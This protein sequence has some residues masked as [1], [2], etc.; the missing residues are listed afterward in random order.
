A[1]GAHRRL[2]AA[3]FRTRPLVEMQRP[4]ETAV[5]PGT[6]AFTIAR[7]EPGEMAEGRIQI[8]THHTEQTV[9]QP[10]WLDHPNGATGLVDIV[11]VVADVAEAAQRYAR[12]TARPATPTRFGQEIV[13]ERGRVQLVTAASFAALLPGIAVPSLP[14]MGAYALSVTS[15]KAA[16]TLLEA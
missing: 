11:I 6:A 4:A 1:A 12:F 7:V 10:R 15:L 3:G 13:L 2:G 14:F 16:A 9:W 5:G 8:L